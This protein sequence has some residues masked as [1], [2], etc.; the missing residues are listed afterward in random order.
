MDDFGEGVDV[1][2]FGDLSVLIKDTSSG[3]VLVLDSDF[4]AMNE[5]D[6]IE[7]FSRIT[8]DGNGHWLNGNLF[9][10]VFSDFNGV[11][12]KNIKFINGLSTGYGGAISGGSNINVINCTFVN[13]I[14]SNGG[15]VYLG[16]NNRIVDCTF[17]GNRATDYGGVMQ[18]SSAHNVVLNCTFEDNFANSA[19]GAITCH[20]DFLSV[21]N[22]SFVNNSASGSYG[23]AIAWFGAHGN[24]VN[25]TFIANKGRSVVYWS[26][27]SYKSTMVNCSFV[28]NSDIDVDWQSGFGNLVNCTFDKSNSI[29]WS[30]AYGKIVFCNFNYPYNNIYSSESVDVVKKYLNLNYDISSFEY[31]DPKSFLIYAFDSFGKNISNF[32]IKLDFIDDN[33][34]NYSIYTTVKNGVISHNSILKELYTGNW[35]INIIFEGDDNYY[36][37]NETTELTVIPPFTSLTI[38]DV[39]S[40]VGNK[41]TLTANLNSTLT[42]DEGVVS[43]F[44][45]ETKIGSSNVNGG[46]AS[47]SYAPSTDGEH[48]IS[49]VFESS[50]YVSSNN[51]CKLLVDSATVEVMVD[52][53]TVGFN[54]TFV[55]NVKSLYSVINDGTVSFYVND[56]FI[57]KS[58]V[59]NGVSSFTYVPLISGDYEIKVVYCNNYFFDVSDVKNYHVD[60][61]ESIIDI[62]DLTSTFGDELTLIAKVCSSNNLSV[63]EG[64]V[65]FFDG[66]TKIGSSNVNGGVASLSYA[67]ST[68]GEHM[69]SAV[70]ESSNYVSSNNTCKLLVDSATVEVMVDKGTVGFN[71][72]FVANVKSLYSVINDGTVS[73]YVNDNFI[74]K[75]V[76][77]NG[78]SSFTYVPLISGDYEIKVVYCNNYFFDV[79]DVKN[80]HVDKA[81]S[82]IDIEDLTSTFGDELT[83]IAKVCSSNNLSVNEG[84]VTFFDGETK[85]GSSN[86]Y[87]GVASLSYTPLAGEHKITVK[88]DSDNYLSCEDVSNIIIDKAE[89]N[90]IIGNV[91]EVY[92][93]SPV[94]FN[95]NVLSHNSMIYD[96]VIKFYIGNNE[97][98]YKN[99][100]GAVTFEYV[101]PN[102][103]DFDL[104][105]I[106]GG[107]NNYL[108]S[109]ATYSFKVNKLSTFIEAS[110]LTTVYNGGKDLI[111][112]LKDQN[113]V[114]LSNE[115]II[116]NFNGIKNIVTD[117]NGQ[118]KLQTNGLVPKSSYAV[119]ITFEGNSNYA[120]VTKNV[121]VTVKKA[122]PKITAKS[123]TFKKSVK[124]KKYTITLK[125]NVN[126]VM[127]NTKV[128]IKV[129]KKTY[130]AKTNSKGVATFK[131]TKLTK[132][133]TFKSV[134][135]YKGSS[136]YNKVTKKVN[137]K[138]K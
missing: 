75:S 128:T 94:V 119:T 132:K 29:S 78:V 18:F 126:K 4:R 76:V 63:N 48:M 13:N 74:F 111:A 61:A 56:N 8:I 60:K 105:A 114:A 7:S 130:T 101:A 67:P 40:V 55:A 3:D 21:I 52:K 68:D 107:T 122:T 77:V 95:I 57:F 51:T 22:C 43:F 54:S 134:I 79:S 121:K 45:G 9:N 93:T 123:K 71:S 39:Y 129:N 14:A 53:G 84:S 109:N 23:A 89:T 65:T 12:L 116:I 81:E 35:N 100:L 58:V 64:S 104:I 28:G 73:F 34:K 133:G 20:G 92:Y 86:V 98:G 88:Y 62:E 42:V 27:N 10:N 108:S 127:K 131:I 136:Y 47:L 117:S 99:V 70:F 97:V 118:V 106:Y 87:N 37:A 72:T 69:I 82:I 16:S 96:G 120:S 33:E 24:L 5:S 66:E 80:Y 11:T 91:D 30:G 19:I 36:P 15:A 41:T 102:S 17:V 115:N 31:K 137:I 32:N 83:L 90:I 25:S 103:G 1:G 59:V 110:S 46:V 50:N 124:T 44:D 2:S 112:S 49:A 113:G 26:S 135:T 6:R 125:N 38:S 138:V 85:I